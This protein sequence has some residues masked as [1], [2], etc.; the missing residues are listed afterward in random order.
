MEKQEL[1]PEIPEENGN[2]LVHRRIRNVLLN[3][4]SILENLFGFSKEV[5]RKGR[6]FAV[7]QMVK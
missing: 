4:C 6:P 5:L 2:G 1:Y 3:T 7:V